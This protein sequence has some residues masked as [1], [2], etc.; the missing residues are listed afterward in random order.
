MYRRLFYDPAKPSAFSTVRKLKAAVAASK[1]KKRKRQDVESWLQEQDAFTMHRPTRKRF[2]RNPYTVDNAMD[3]WECDLIDV[4]SLK[5][6]NDGYGYLLTV[7][8]VFT[9][10]I[11]VV[12]LRA[13]TGTAVAMAFS[14]I[15]ADSRYSLKTGVRRPVWVRTDRGKEFLN[16]S[17]RDLLKREGILSQVCRNP[18]VK[19]SIVE[20][21]QRT[22]REKMYKYF[23]YKNTRRYVDVL[24]RLV[25]AYNDTPHTA[26]GLA[27]SRVR[28][29]DVL[30]IWRRANAKRRRVAIAKFSIG[31][32]VR[33]SKEK[34]R[35]AKGGE[36]NYSTEI[37]KISKVIRR[38][39]RPVYELRDLKGREIEGQFYGEEVTPVRITAH[40]EYKIDKI[41]ETRVRGGIR[42]HLVRWKGYGP[43]F[44][45]WIPASSVRN[46]RRRQHGRKR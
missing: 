19:C 35:F 11:H 17:F 5:R 3:V 36:Q 20:R 22:V 45:S 46:I 18:D 41:L 7:I 29:T 28:D 12:P 14:S 16:R 1:G 38:T 26:T 39:P 30:K 34:L 25:R 21:A 27:P 23:T 2:P 42:E 31:Q 10:Y 9:R 33:I 4:R 6:Y 15:L 8:D 44:D 40:T 43:D 24:D 32:H 37:F 13:K